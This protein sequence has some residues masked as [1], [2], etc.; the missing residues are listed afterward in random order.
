MKAIT[1]WQPW[2][3]LIACGAK[4][5]ET[6]SWAT[7]YRGPIAIHA[8]LKDPCKLP[9]L[10]LEDFEEAVQKAFGDVSSSWCLLP[11]GA[12]IATAELVDCWHIVH[13]PGADADRASLIEIGAELDVPK[14]SPRFGDFI[15][16]NEQELL[17]GDWTPGR[18]AWELQ[19]IQL[20]PSPIYVKGHQGLWIFDMAQEAAKD[21]A[22][23]LLQPAT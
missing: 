13:C 15:E 6:R 4:K 23:Y 7:N 16:P 10:G 11:R 1:I 9:L 22:A 3:S 17:F 14:H 18:Y 19:N 20:L 2:A 21:T 5:Y 8:A 12:V